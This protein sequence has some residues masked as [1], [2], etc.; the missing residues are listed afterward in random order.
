M[1]KS[2]T[3]KIEDEKAKTKIKNPQEGFFVL[4]N[5]FPSLPRRGG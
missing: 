3:L 2:R 4:A 5:F 1:A